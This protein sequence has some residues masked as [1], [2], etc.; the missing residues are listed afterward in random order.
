MS[1]LTATHRQSQYRL[2]QGINRNT[3]ESFTQPWYATSQVRW[4]LN[5][6]NYSPRGASTK[7]PNAENRGIRPSFRFV[8][9][10][11]KE[12]EDGD[13]HLLK[14]VLIELA[15]KSTMKVVPHS[16]TNVEK[17]LL[18]Q[19]QHDYILNQQEANPKWITVSLVLNDTEIKVVALTILSAEAVTKKEKHIDEIGGAQRFNCAQNERNRC[20][21]L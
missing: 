19:G 13:E 10:K 8:S 16:F 7:K 17:F 1:S 11:I 9:Y 5:L 3:F 21:G 12:R 2:L 4:Q 14:S 18:C 20:E 6:L 15:P